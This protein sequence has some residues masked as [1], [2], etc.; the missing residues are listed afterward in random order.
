[1]IGLIT[2][3]LDSHYS[4]SLGGEEVDAFYQSDVTCWSQI[5]QKDNVATIWC[6][7]CQG[8]VGWKD[9]GGQSSCRQTGNS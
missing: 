1:V 4:F 9:D 2:L 5:K 3:N 6:S 7:E 8:M